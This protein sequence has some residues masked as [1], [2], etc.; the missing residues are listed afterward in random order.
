MKS[1]CLPF[2]VTVV[3]RTDSAVGVMVLD[4]VPFEG[5]TLPSFEPGAHIDVLTPAGAIR[6]YSICNNPETSGYRLGILLNPSSRGDR[7]ACTVRSGRVIAC[8]LVLP[9]ISFRY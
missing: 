6:Q 2:E 9:E 8:T 5:G 3:K 7:Q 1:E 4:L